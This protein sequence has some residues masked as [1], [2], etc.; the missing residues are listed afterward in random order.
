M[1]CT[2]AFSSI[3]FS[4]RRDAPGLAASDRDQAS[5]RILNPPTA[6]R[7]TSKGIL[8]V[9]IFVRRGSFI[10]LA[11]T[12]SRCAR[13]LNT[14]HEKNTVSPGLV[15]TARGNGT[16]HFTLRSSPTHSRY[17]RAP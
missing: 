6:M 9:I 5:T 2:S 16:P 13:D 4:F 15:L 8:D 10:T 17:S 1:G 14:I 12:R 11:L 3:S 7:L